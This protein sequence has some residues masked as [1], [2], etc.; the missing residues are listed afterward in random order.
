MTIEAHVYENSL[1]DDPV[2]IIGFPSVGLVSSIT[3]SYCITQLGLEPKVGLNGQTLPPY[4][5]IANGIAFPPIR[6][7]GGKGRTKTARDVLVCTAEFA[8][9]AEDC[10]E[11]GTAV[12][13]SLRDLGCRQVICLEGMQRLSPEDKMVVCGSD[14]RASAMVDKSG[15]TRL[16]NGMVKGL[17]GI[18]MAECRS[19]GMSVVTILC[20]ADQGLPDPGSAV[21]FLEP[22]SRMV[23]G[24]KLSP[25]PLL[26]E[27]EQIKK[28]AS[29]G[30][31]NANDDSHTILYG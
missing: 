8:P 23:K 28:K 12:L 29:E 25:K 14:S 30:H 19:M 1:L 24:L 18:M 3:A 27:A 10:Y 6:I 4:C 26:E 13:R 31:A 17:S 11:V 16:D 2:A 22:L 9:K 15:L 21:G 7:F 5:I 20:P